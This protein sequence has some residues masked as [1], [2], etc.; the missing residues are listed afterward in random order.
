[1]I[2]S[3]PTFGNWALEKQY[4]AAQ[5]YLSQE[6]SSSLNETQR[7]QLGA[8]H[9]QATYGTCIPGVLLPDLQGSSTL[10]KKKRE[11]E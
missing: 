9:M 11:E 3:S 4:N 2:S 8:L 1:M 5:F 6:K 10:I 7:L